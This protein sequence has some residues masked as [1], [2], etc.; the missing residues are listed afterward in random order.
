[1]FSYYIMKISKRM[2]HA[3]RIKYTKRAKYTRHTKHGRG[4]QYKNKRT[5]RKHPRKL[6][7]KS[8]LQKGGYSQVNTSGQANNSFVRRMYISYKKKERGGIFG[9]AKDKNRIFNEE[10]VVSVTLTNVSNIPDT[11]KELT[12]TDQRVFTFKIELSRI[13]EKGTKFELTLTKNAGNDI[14]ADNYNDRQEYTK[15]FKRD[16]QPLPDPLELQS[17]DESET[18]IFTNFPDFLWELNKPKSLNF[19]AFE[20][21]GTNNE[22]RRIIDTRVAN[23]KADKKAAAEGAAAAVAVAKGEEAEQPPDTGT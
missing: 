17:N 5:Y 7:H 9:F 21:L 15:L 14:Y 1:M 12:P 18:Y 11:Y 19:F 8:R 4:K 13:S 23:E 6:K 16:G 2:R 22:F 10:F 3:K 20:I